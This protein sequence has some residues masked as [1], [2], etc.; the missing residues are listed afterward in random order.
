MMILT[1]LW[2][3]I[4]TPK[5]EFDPIATSLTNPQ[6]AILITLD[7][8]IRQCSTLD[9]VPTAIELFGALS[10]NSPDWFDYIADL[11]ILNRRMFICWDGKDEDRVLISPRGSYIATERKKSDNA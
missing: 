11:T 4:W 5:N 8:W 1:Q 9:D 2:H 6:A 3:W 10:A 7:S